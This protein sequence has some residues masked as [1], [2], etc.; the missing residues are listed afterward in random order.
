MRNLQL[1]LAL[2]LLA[3]ATVSRTALAQPTCDPSENVNAC[4]NQYNP[5]EPTVEGDIYA[6][7]WAG[8][9]YAGSYGVYGL[10]NAGIG[11]GGVAS[12]GYGLYGLS[13]SS[14]AIFGDVSAQ[15][16]GSNAGVYGNSDAYGY[17]VYGITNDGVAGVFGTT[18]YTYGVEG[19][20]TNTNGTGVYGHTTSAT[21]YGVEGV[22]TTGI[23]I[24]AAGTSSSGY[25]GT[26]I[27]ATGSGSASYGINA[28]TTG[29]DGG[30]AA[31]NATSGGGSSWAGYFNGKVGVS[32][33]IFVGSCSGCTSDIRLKKDVKP[34]AGAID[35]L[36]SLKGV[37]FEWKNPE[38]HEGHAGTQIGFIAQD[39]QKLYPEWV[40]DGGYTAPDGQKYK[41]LDTR[42]IEALEV[43][44]IRTLKAKNDAQEQ[45][46][47]AL[48]DGRPIPA[49][50]GFNFGGSNVGLLGLAAAIA[51]AAS[52]R[53]QGERRA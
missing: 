36:L 7:V 51:Y 25:H 28:W 26:G 21:G 22:S 30:S 4:F 16:S 46:L 19:T 32:G 37:T 35:Q 13:S 24:Y 11:V 43:E 1:H 39:V 47:K 23:G 6:G 10:N 9:T 27:Y 53:K 38:E 5:T 15:T 8:E 34:L 3:A 49:S 48:E 45:R 42:Q 20:G 44:S 33:E 2:T 52:R 29:T 40:K 31:V 18:A 41:T 17:G 50:T 12:S 14:H